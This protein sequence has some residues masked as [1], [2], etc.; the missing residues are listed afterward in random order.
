MA[1]ACSGGGSISVGIL[2]LLTSLAVSAGC[3][4]CERQT[5][6]VKQVSCNQRLRGETASSRLP[7]P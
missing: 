4:L 6:P 5:S 2:E 1:Q 7:L 3:L